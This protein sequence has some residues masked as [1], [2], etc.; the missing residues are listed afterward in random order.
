[1]LWLGNPNLLG[2][3]SLPC[4]AARAPRGRSEAPG[5]ERGSKIPLNRVSRTTRRDRLGAGTDM[6][7][8]KTR[9]EMLVL[10]P[11]SVGGAG[12]SAPGRAGGHG[13]GCWWPMG[14]IGTQGAPQG[15]VWTW[16]KC[17]SLLT[18]LP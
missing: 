9:R 6:Q 5:D 8:P 15:A 12:G 10:P 14:L 3:S 16:V 2:R 7:G 13:V 1:M 17:K 11:A 4:P 18:T